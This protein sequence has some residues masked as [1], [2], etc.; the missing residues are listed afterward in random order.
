MNCRIFMFFICC[1]V[2]INMFSED[3]K[4]WYKKP[5]EEWTEALPIGNGRQ[6]AMVFGG[7]DI[8]HLQL[9]ENTLYSGDP[10]TVYKDVKITPQKFHEIVEL[11]KNGNYEKATLEVRKHWLG[12]LHQCYQPL[13]DL[14]ITDN[15]KGQVTDYKRELDINTSQHI[16]SYKRNGVGYYRRYYASYPDNIIV[17]HYKSAKK[18]GIDIF[19]NFTSQHN[20][21]LQSNDSYDLV[22]KGQA[23]AY[24]SK[25]PFSDIEEI[26]DQHKHPEIYDKFGNRKYNTNVLYGDVLGGR[27][28]FFE[29]RLRPVLTSGGKCEFTSK[30][31]RVYK[32]DEVYFVISLSTSFNGYDKDPAFNGINPSDKNISGINK[33]MDYSADECFQRHLSDYKKLFERVS[34]KLGNSRS[35][36]KIPTDERIIGYS[37][38]EDLELVTLLFQYGR[39]LLISGSREGGQPLNLQGMWNNEIVPPWNSA[40]TANI[41]LEMNYWP[42][43]VTSLS[44]CNAPFFKMI[45]ELAESGKETAKN[46]YNCDGWV[47]HHATSIWRETYPND[48]LPRAAF[49]P[50]GAGWLC[51]HLWEHYQY[52]GDKDFLLEKAYPLMKSAC[53]FFLDWMIFEDGYW[54]TPV[55]VS[56]ENRFLVDGKECHVSMGSTMDMAIIREIFNN[57]IKANEILGS[58]EDSVLC[59]EIKNKL[60]H[61]LPYKIGS[62]GQLM[63]WKNEFIEHDIHHRHLSHLYG[64]HPGNEITAISTPELFEAVRKTLEIRGDEATGWSMGWKLNFW[65]RMMDGNHANKIIKNMFTPIGFGSSHKNNKG[66]VYANLFDAHPPFQIDGNFGFTAGIAEMLMQSHCGYIH[67]LPAL[68]DS[69]SSGSIKGLKARGNFSIDI[70]WSGNKLRKAVIL[71]NIGRKC[72]LVYDKP[73]IIEYSRKKYDSESLFINGK[74][75]F[76][77]ELNTVKNGKYVV[78][79][80]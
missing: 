79:L 32:T 58:S 80:K 23:P 71:S 28:M 66:G 59:K 31:L 15:I 68:P 74:R 21:A 27:G 12:R 73:F 44:E 60:K 3:L 52:T 4:L 33:V 42:T 24:I 7:I 55:S 11:I 54:Q 46:M 53:S 38:V 51:S 63:E 16:I 57:T 34:F 19:L 29:G 6:G 45:E 10:S 36:D 25:R 13:G 22:I 8:E 14:Y 65:A 1:F 47:F 69:W 2:A 56:P 43:E 9:N 49:W 77:C 48:R 76:V 72:R 17:L 62:K 64:F 75:F 5:A 40:Y 30:G 67:I 39:Y 20:N 37:N 35:L 70:E 26:G 18:N 61:I 50:M 78:T 41:N